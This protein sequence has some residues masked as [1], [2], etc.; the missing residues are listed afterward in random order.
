[1][2]YKVQRYKCR[3]VRDGSMVVPRGTIDG[4][5]D[6]AE[7]FMKTLKGLPHEEMHVIFING[8]NKVIG[9]EAVARGSSTGMILRTGDIMRS[10]LAVNARAIIVGHNHPSGNSKPSQDDIDFMSALYRAGAILGIRLLDSLVVCPETKQ[11]TQID[12]VEDD[13]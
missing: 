1:M 8:D 7:F 4:A 3:L 6:S 13:D 12:F 10:A 2:S 9:F 11:W 5:A